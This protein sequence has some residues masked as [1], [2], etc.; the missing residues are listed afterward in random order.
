MK[1]KALLFVLLWCIPVFSEIPLLDE[2]LPVKAFERVE[3]IGEPTARF[4][5]VFTTADRN[6]TIR[7]DGRG[8]S[9]SNKILR[10]NF[11]LRVGPGA[12][13]ERLY[14]AEYQSDLLL[15]YEVTD[16]RSGWGYLLCLDQVKRQ[17]K[18]LLPIEGVNIGP[19]VIEGNNV[20]LS[21]ADFV[22]RVDLRSGKYAWRDKELEKSYAP[23]F[24]EFLQPIVTTDRVLFKEDKEEGRVVEVDKGSGQVMAVKP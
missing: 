18:W 12:K 7:H 14:F 24:G 21:A 1:I 9:Y 20:Y 2:S 3:R 15:L 6:Y 23:T 22:A 10:R 16:G 17:T 5:Y 11:E 8:E 19:A 13:L 4:F